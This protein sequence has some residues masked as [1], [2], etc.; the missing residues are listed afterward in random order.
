MFIDYI[1][2]KGVKVEVLSNGECYFFFT[3][4]WFVGKVQRYASEP[5]GKGG[6]VYYWLA[7]RSEQISKETIEKYIRKAESGTEHYHVEHAFRWQN[8]DNKPMH[9][10]PYNINITITKR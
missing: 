4:G 6:T 7:E 5:D 10:L 9:E 2:V 1:K 8:E 3:V